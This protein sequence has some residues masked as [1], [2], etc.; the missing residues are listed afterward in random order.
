MHPSRIPTLT[1]TCLPGMGAALGMAGRMDAA[2]VAL[3]A[4]IGYRTVHRLA[5]NL[6][7]LRAA[8]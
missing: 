2:V 6:A 5:P 7:G 8:A 3:Q 1:A 4:G